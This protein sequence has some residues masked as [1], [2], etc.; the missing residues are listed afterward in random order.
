MSLILSVLILP[1]A[2]LAQ[3]EAIYTIGGLIAKLRT[4]VWAGF[5]IIATI[6]F[7]MS[8]ILL[9]ISGGQVEKIK[10]ARQFFMWGIAGVVAG[11]LVYLIITLIQALL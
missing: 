9:L 6:C 3:T 2:V 5:G 1:V 4:A 10:T 11:I 7:V 8:G